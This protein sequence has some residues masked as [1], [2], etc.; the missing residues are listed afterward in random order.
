MRAYK[1]EKGRGQ[2]K[3]RHK[4]E[5]RDIVLEGE[6]DPTGLPRRPLAAD[7]FRQTIGGQAQ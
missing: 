4:V 5:Q 1:A 3:K 2:G 6:I 7:S